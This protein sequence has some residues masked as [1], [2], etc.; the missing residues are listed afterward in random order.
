MDVPVLLLI[1]SRPRHVRR[2]VEVLRRVGCRT[3][4]IGGDG[5]RAGEAEDAERCLAAR[6]E[7]L[8]V[9]ASC[10]VATRF[11]PENRG[12]EAAVSGAITWFFE[13]HERGIVLEEDCV[14]DESF[15][16]FC[17]E[18]LD[19][20]ADH[21][22][23]GAITG[24]NFQRG[25]TRGSSSY[26][27]SRYPHCWGWATW[28]RAWQCYDRA[29]CDHWTSESWRALPETGVNEKAYWACIRRLTIDGV[30]DS[31]ANRWTHSLWREGLLTATPQRN[32][33]DN[34][35]IGKD[36]THTRSEY[37]RPPRAGP[38]AFPLVHPVGV[39][40]DADADRFVA[41]HHFRAGRW[42]LMWAAHAIRR[43]TAR[44]GGESSGTASL[45]R[46]RT[47]A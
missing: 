13:N 5:P 8:N 27:F 22:R 30:Q 26:Y 11:L 42:P 45:E 15:F 41:S 4:F 35:G 6:Q 1:H 46:R 24:N 28:R 33:V 16:G 7:A 20:Y 39:E 34:I 31:W 43:A 32:L 37:L 38:I 18:L 40:C 2:V 47:S 14:P 19:A 23:V 3:L 29:A 17:A 36:S 10:A 44:A 12:C 21:P 9:D 25:R